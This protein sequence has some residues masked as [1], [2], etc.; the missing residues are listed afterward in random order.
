M[1]KKLIRIQLQ[2]LV[3]YGEKLIREEKRLSL[4]FTSVRTKELTIIIA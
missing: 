1:L 2:S 3:K 4:A